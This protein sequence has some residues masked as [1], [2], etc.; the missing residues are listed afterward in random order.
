MEEDELLFFEDKAG[1]SAAAA[2]SQAGR[3]AAVTKEE[4]R[5]AVSLFGTWCGLCLWCWLLTITRAGSMLTAADDADLDLFGTKS[6]KRSRPAADAPVWQDDDE[7]EGA[8]DDEVKEHKTAGE[9]EQRL[10]EEYEERRGP[11]PAWAQ[12]ATAEAPSAALFGTTAS[13]TQSGA[14][15]GVLET[16]VLRVQKLNNLNQQSPST[17]EIDNVQFSPTAQVALTAGRDKTMRLFQVNQK[18]CVKLHSIF[19]EDL[20]IKRAQFVPRSHDV[21]CMG[22]KK[23][24]YLYDME[25]DSVTRVPHLIGQ[26]EQ[27][28]ADVVQS[29]DGAYSTFL[30]GESGN[31]VL[32]SNRSRQVAH[33]L[34]MSAPVT[35]AAYGG[36]E[37]SPYLWTT[38]PE[39][40]VFKWDM[41]STR[42]CVGKYRDQGAIG[43]E[44]IAN[45]PDGRWQAVGDKSGVV[46]VYSLAEDAAPGVPHKAIG[47]LVTS[48]SI[49]AWGPDS[50]TLTIASPKT[51]GALRVVHVPSFTVF[52]NWPM[53]SAH[54]Q[55]VSS[56]AL[57]PSSGYLSVGNR[58]GEA[59]L[60]R[61][62]S[63]PRY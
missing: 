61:L 49:L 38:G 51:M 63:Y 35:R 6:N 27:G 14:S 17:A 19:F 9:Y 7:D 18:K 5:L 52:S 34:K 12:Q 24:F 48:A 8:G 25:H 31:V 33:V 28:W 41:R 46:N 60:F 53:D 43:T 57:S 42:R 36:E 45:S 11:Q 4:E 32:F 56:V 22:Y 10:R 47:N 3:T 54:L 23:P 21:L 62:L 26:M 44:T 40:D 2:A 13:V 37:G 29:P 58:K 16:G 55:F 39:C 50:Q 20:P 30:G 1:E 59:Q 15:V